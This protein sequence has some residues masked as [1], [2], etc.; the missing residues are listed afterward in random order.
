Q[1][2]WKLEN[3]TFYLNANDTLLIRFRLKTN[4]T[5]NDDGWYIDDLSISEVNA[6]EELSENDNDFM[7]YPNPAQSFITFSFNLSN[8]PL[9]KNFKIYNLY[10]TEIPIQDF[11]ISNNFINLNIDNLAS[12]V[13]I[14]EFENKDGQKNQKI[15]SKIK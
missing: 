1:D 6:V 10:G 3:L 9:I 12:G 5:R 4:V 14:F 8:N 7:L 13:Y 11:Y 2:D 15:F